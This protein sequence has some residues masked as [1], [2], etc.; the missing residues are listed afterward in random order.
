MWFR[1]IYG[2]LTLAK[3][4]VRRFT[5][6]TLA[7]FSLTRSPPL[8]GVLG[9]PKKENTAHISLSSKRI[10]SEERQQIHIKPLRMQYGRNCLRLFPAS[11][12]FLYLRQIL[13]DSASERNLMLLFSLKENDDYETRIKVC[14][15]TTFIIDR[16]PLS[17]FFL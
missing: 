8:E 13:R 7:F 15:Y 4:N 6:F 11:F 5:S 3:E 9:L 10:M 16:V 2:I 1:I 17:S 14:C 12:V